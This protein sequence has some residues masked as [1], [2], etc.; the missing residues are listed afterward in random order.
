MLM[1]TGLITPDRA[2]D[3]PPVLT[4]ELTERTEPEPAA[5]QQ[6]NETKP[7]RQEKEE[8]A[9]TKPFQEE[10]VDLGDAR[11]PYL[12]YLKKIKKKIIDLWNYPR[13]AYLR[14]EEGEVVVRFSLNRR[15]DLEKAVVLNSSGSG[16]LDQGA[17]DVV[18]SA[19]PY[20]P[21]PGELTLS[22][23]HIVGTFKYRLDK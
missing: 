1:V 15:G 7:K 20:D 18:H 16:F 11:S 10:T 13:E 23:L 22:K 17:I 12:P 8:S 3:P 2:G 21:F 9:E 19:A 14:R 6:Q 5:E 4:V